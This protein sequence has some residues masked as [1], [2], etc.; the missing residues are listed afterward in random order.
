LLHIGDTAAD[1][2]LRAM[3]ESKEDA[4]FKKFKR[5]IARSPTQVLRY[6]REGQP[7]WVLEENQHGQVPPCTYCGS[8]RVF[9]FQVSIIL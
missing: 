7:L 4:V 6:E 1:E 5:R 3:P 8:P 2:D 9:E